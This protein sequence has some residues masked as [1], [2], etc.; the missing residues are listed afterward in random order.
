VC[1][2]ISELAAE[3]LDKGEWPEV[4]PALQVRHTSSSTGLGVVR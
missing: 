3:L 4:L 2:T 1:D